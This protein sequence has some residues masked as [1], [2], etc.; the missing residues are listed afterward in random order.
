MLKYKSDEQQG[1]E[2]YPDTISIRLDI[3]SFHY[4]VNKIKIRKI[5]L[6][7]NYTDNVGKMNIIK[8]QN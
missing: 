5:I 2:L 3:Y 8:C 1:N 4:I 7:I 6:V